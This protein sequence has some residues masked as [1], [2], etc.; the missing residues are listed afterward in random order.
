M[1]APFKEL[2]SVAHL[3]TPLGSDALSAAGAP[4]RRRRLVSSLLIRKY[5]NSLVSTFGT[6][7]MNRVS[8]FI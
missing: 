3:G 7:L 6:T 2:K 4:D 1:V 8:F 5:P